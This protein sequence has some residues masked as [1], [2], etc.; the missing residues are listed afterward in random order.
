MEG[1]APNN[2]TFPTRHFESHLTLSTITLPIYH[3]RATEEVEDG[4]EV[5][6][7][8]ARTVVDE[9]G[10]GIMVVVVVAVVVS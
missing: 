1:M 8:K 6:E 5:M 10:E 3:Y 7:I 2:F 4:I 9:D